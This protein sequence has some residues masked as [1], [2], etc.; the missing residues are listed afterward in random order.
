[1]VAGCTTTSPR[2]ATPD[3]DTRDGAPE[4]RDGAPETRD[5]ALPRQ[6]DGGPSRRPFDWVGVIGAG[7]SLALGCPTAAL[8]TTPSFHNLMLRDDGP[9]PRY[10]VDGG[11]SARWSVVPLVEPIREHVPGYAAS[12][13][14]YPNN[15][16]LTDGHYGETPH[17]AFAN[18][19]SA[20]WAARGDGD[21]VT[22][23]SVVAYGGACLS[24][25]GR[26]DSTAGGR[27]YAAG[28]A[29]ARVFARLAAAAGRSYGVAGILFT[30]GECD[31][32][33][34]PYNPMYGA[35]LYQLWR[36]YNND[37]RAA[38]GQTR[39]VV[40]FATQ[41]SG[42]PAGLN[43]PNVQLWRA[44]VE[45]PEQ[46][47]CVGPKY[48]YGDYG[49]HLPNAAA[50]QRLGEKYAEVFDAVVNR[51]VAW[52][53]VGPRTATRSGAT[54]RIA[55]DVP[56]PPL[57]WDTHLAPP[58]QTMHTAWAHGR[59]F[60]VTDPAGN[61]VAIASAEIDGS[62]VVLTLAR[63]PA[64]GTTLTLAYALTQDGG[65][66]LGGYDAG[67]HGLLRDSDD[68]AGAS[69]ESI[70]VMATHGSDTITAPDGAFARR[71]NLDIVTGTGVPADTV[72]R[73]AGSR[74][75]LSAPWSGA[76]GVTTL[77]FRHDHHNY[78]VHFA[79]P[80]P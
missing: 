62:D 61:E 26:Q 31:S 54:I 58:H 15:L 2:V 46:I 69:A 22:A 7:Q 60:E 32:Q 47:V 9:D 34:P 4:T 72:V 53:P 25:I 80:V 38:T 70:A 18:T 43:G 33:N 19:L 50:Y 1:M 12:D 10:P 59:G 71:A 65:G 36:D 63:A 49:V 78:C 17:P 20:T 45:H 13:G 68:F 64:A 40:L 42:L 8:S 6:T 3:A 73:T 77:N 41:Q 37:L 67:M 76:T 56:N 48:A 11:T 55:F 52:R 28:I 16:C 35:Q 30:H 27:T 66:W 74:I 21:Y 57:V 44:S 39:D 23:H 24:Q 5:G 79:M 29:E 75:T 51:G 14:Q